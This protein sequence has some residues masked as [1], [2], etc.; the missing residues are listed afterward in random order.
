MAR[1]ATF[2]ADEIGVLITMAAIT[3][4]VTRISGLQCFED[5]LRTHRLG[6]IPVIR[7]AN[8]EWVDLASVYAVSQE[9][10]HNR[11]S[12]PKAEQSHFLFVI[13]MMINM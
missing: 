6:R 8:R 7:A 3:K 1:N 13:A 4:L 11:R 12:R 5:V 9:I 10:G 2:A